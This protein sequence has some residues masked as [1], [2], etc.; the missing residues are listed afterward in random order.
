MEGVLK[1]R[2]PLGLS[3]SIH[4]KSSDATYKYFVSIINFRPL[5]MVL[6]HVSYCFLCHQVYFVVKLRRRRNDDPTV[7]III[8]SMLLS[9][10]LG[11]GQR[12]R[13][14]I[15]LT[16]I[17]SNYEIFF[18]KLKYNFNQLILYFY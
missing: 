6:S 7:I 12:N 2:I 10:P 1:R 11:Q 8:Y 5:P 16:L 18:N 13:H 4:G 9:E 17:Q 3:S 15:D 14:R